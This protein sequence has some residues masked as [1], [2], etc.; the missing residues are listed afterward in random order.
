MKYRSVIILILIIFA[1]TTLLL[2]LGQVATATQNRQAQQADAMADTNPGV[3]L[4]GPSTPGINFTT[5]YTENIGLVSIVDSTTLTVTDTDDIF[6]ASATITLMNQP[7]GQDE[8]IEIDASGTSLI[9]DYQPQTGVLTLS[10][11]NGTDSLTNFQR[12]LR[13]ITYINASENPDPTARTVTFIVNDGHA[14]SPP[15]EATIFMLPVNDAPILD[16]SEDIALGTLPEDA[17]INEGDTVANILNEG[18]SSL[19]TDP[20]GPFSGIGLIEAD[21]SN[22]KWQYQSGNVWLDVGNV[23]EETAVLL[24]SSTRLRFLPNTD[25]TGDTGIRF[26]AWDQSNGLPNGSSNI[27][28][29][30]NGSTTPYSSEIVNANLAVI[31]QNDPPI[32]DLNGPDAGTKFQTVFVE[33]AGFTPIVAETALTVTD[34]D[35][36]LL[37]FATV[38]LTTMPDGITETLTATLTINEIDSSYNAGSGELR[39]TGPATPSQFQQVLRSVAYNNLSQHPNNSDRIVEFIVSDGISNSV[40][41]ISTIAINRVN[42]APILA[43][44][45]PIT[46]TAIDEDDADS[47]G[48]LVENIIATGGSDPISDVDGDSFE[49]IAVIGVDNSNGR[50]QYRLNGTTEWA[51]FTAVSSISGT[52]LSGE[53][54][55]RFLPDPDYVGTA[56]FIF[57]AWDHSDNNPVGAMNI[58]TNVNGG[59]T[60]FSAAQANATITVLGINDAPILDLNG[61]D[62]PGREFTADFDEGLG[63]I[64]I[65]SPTLTLLD[66]DNN[67]IL[68]AQIAITNLLDGADESLQATTS[69]GVVLNYNPTAGILTLSGTKRKEDYQDILRTIT[70]NNS[71]L[72]PAD[73]ENRY[74]VFTV[75]DESGATSI[76][77]TSTVRI[78]PVNN[79]PIINSFGITSTEDSLVSLTLSRFAP[80]FADPDGD[81]LTEVKIETLPAQGLLLFDGTPIGAGQIIPADYLNKLAFQPPEHWFGTTAFDWNGKDDEVYPATGGTVTLY[82]TPEND[83]PT[84]NSVERVGLEDERL[85]FAAVDFVSQFNDIDGDALANIRIKTLPGRGTLRFGETPVMIDDEISVASLNQLSYEPEQDWNGIISFDWDASDGELYSDVVATVVV[86]ITAVNDAPT[87][88][89]V[90]KFGSEDNILPFA[91]SDFAVRFFDIEGN[92]LQKI[93]IT[94]LPMHG[95][96]YLD[97]VPI[98]AGDEIDVA[99]IDEITFIPEPEWHGN[100]QFIWNGFD[101]DVYANSNAAVNLTITPVNDAPALDLNGS[102]AGTEFDAAFLPTSG[103]IPIVSRELELVDVDSTT[104]VSAIITLEDRLDGSMEELAADAGETAVSITYN[105]T[106]G[107]L[108]LTG[109]DSVANYQNVLR[110]LIYNNNS[111]A[112]TIGN[113]TVTFI[114]SDGINDSEATQSHII[115]PRHTF[116][117]VMP[118]RFFPSDEPN[119]NCQQAYMLSPNQTYEFLPNDQEDWYEIHMPTASNLTVSLTNFAPQGDG[120]LI[121][122]GGT[123]P[124]ALVSLGQNGDHSTTKV[125]NLGN[126]PAGTYY[127][128]VFS[129]VPSTTPYR[130]RIQN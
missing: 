73:H 31:P 109:E 17:T 97:G 23:T 44:T 89:D 78:N 66:V 42:D 53:E 51:E 59:T 49:G 64:S 83:A 68:S 102:Q 61:V 98:L 32:I 124:S 71:S 110:T 38:T 112:P 48:N 28:T 130:L 7:D 16:D 94:T 63:A 129:S 72:A 107:V 119:N 95:T 54:R 39:L 108:E 87:L 50:W 4:N 34:A 81:E 8:G 47:I 14:E 57:R 84:L 36:A 99:N 74:I 10:P 125:L 13:T 70:Y 37:E 60:A 12:A 69:S 1:S 46:L 11:V 80:H 62:I 15:A 111:P 122:Y 77:V 21:N 26:R 5:L 79:V 91:V 3:D 103:A 114:V 25:F 30:K 120:Q 43:P 19:I 58:N 105:V 65:V 123:C 76:P 117:P 101:G 113:R 104:I 92:S 115:P 27:N 128:R 45:A 41:A 29:L 6:L 116:M 67:N 35:T 52:L 22:G 33:D 9:V 20:D 121:A 18:G 56:S 82:V 88:N 85:W 126:R 127:I 93:I 24:D 40:A 96:L 90:D 86:S 106:T 55:I 75:T 118:N 100:T 2:A